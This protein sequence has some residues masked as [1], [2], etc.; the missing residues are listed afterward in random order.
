MVLNLY[1]LAW[2]PAAAVLRRTDAEVAHARTVELMR[3]ADALGSMAGMAGMADRLMRRAV[4]RQPVTVGGVVLPQ[5]IIVA[6]GL[7]KGDGFADERSAVAAVRRGRN[8][9]P[10]WRSVPAFVGAVEFG[11]FTRQPRLGNSGRVLWRDS[12]SWS[13]QNRVGLRNPGARAAAMHLRD[14]VSG[15]PP[16]WGINLAVSPGVHDAE[17]SAAELRQCA[18]FF[19][20]AFGDRKPGPAWY[21]LN[22]SCPN[23]E[24]DPLGN[25]TESLARRLT[26]V[27]TESVDVPVWVKLGPD[28]SSEQRRALLPAIAERGARAVVATNTIASPSPHGGQSAGISGAALRPRALR[29]VRQLR[30]DIDE[31]GLPLDVIAC[32]GI[33]HGADWLAF[34]AAGARAAMLYSALVFRGPWAAALILREARLGSPRG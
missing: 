16:A 10:G 2:K 26:A 23:T 24:D 8:I 21:T 5:P 17:R 13:M 34:Q 28:L 11:S 32:G 3:R 27:L 20:R 19:A 29:A 1:E 7:V 12:A 33:L 4:P 30:A 9:V 15:L 6:A 22:L 18:E 31:G 14:R 25:Q